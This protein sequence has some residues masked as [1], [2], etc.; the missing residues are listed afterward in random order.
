MAQDFFKHVWEVVRHIPLG[1]VATYGQIA[2]I[3]SSPRAART[4]GWAL[5]AVPE[6]SDIPWHRVINS[7][8]RISIDCFE[9]DPNLQRLLLEQ[10]GVI[11]DQRGYVDLPVFQW[12]PTA[13]ELIEMDRLLQDDVSHHR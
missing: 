3:I 5:H 13:E 4:V 7:K 10:E 8:G 12:R 9:H 11:F 2:S 6:N 1:R